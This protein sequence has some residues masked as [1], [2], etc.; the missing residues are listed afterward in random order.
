M[1]LHGL[2]YDIFWVLLKFL[3]FG[4][5]AFNFHF[6]VKKKEKKIGFLVVKIGNLSVFS[7]ATKLSIYVILGMV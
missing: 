1:Y 4:F 2:L 7:L 6:S 5:W 3:W